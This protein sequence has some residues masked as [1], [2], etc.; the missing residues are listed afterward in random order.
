MF[1]GASD[2]LWIV[3][4]SLKMIRFYSPVLF[5]FFFPNNFELLF[6]NFLHG[7]DFEF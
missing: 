6:H 5:G 4:L 7:F 1:H 2:I 3:E